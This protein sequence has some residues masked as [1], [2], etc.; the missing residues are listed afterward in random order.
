MAGEERS[1][2]L[3]K[4]GAEAVGTFMITATAI[5]VDVLYFSRGHLEDV[6]RWLA[7]G[8][9]ATAVI[10]A[11]AGT[12]G[13]HANPVVTIAF[14]LRRIFPLRFTVAYVAAQFVGAF[15]AA[16]MLWALFGSQLA[17]GASRPGPGFFP[18]DAV[19]CEIVLTFAFIIVILMTAQ[20]QAVV[21][22][23]AAI[24]VGFVVAACG[25]A[26]GG[27]SGASMNPARSLAAQVVAGTLSSSWVY[28]VGPLLG[29]AAAVFAH[30]LLAGPPTQGARR[31][32]KG[33]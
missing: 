3:R 14:A 13:A 17:L 31:A 21:G 28:V 23:Q 20:E 19:A 11:F 15:V 1:L 30:Q 29:A 24:A 2:L 27:I 8:L 22:P 33:R 10:Y 16:L 18:I 32:A 5:S 25:F 12:S 9:I 6:S 26:G 4:L 7:R